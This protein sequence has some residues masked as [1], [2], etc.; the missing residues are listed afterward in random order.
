MIVK[1]LFPWFIRVVVYSS[2]LPKGLSL[3]GSWIEEAQHEAL[4][5]AKQKPFLDAQQKAIAKPKQ[6]IYPTGSLYYD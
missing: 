4:Q 3:P 6:E 5:E 1:Y 2:H